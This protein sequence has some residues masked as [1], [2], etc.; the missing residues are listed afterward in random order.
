[1][2]CI[3]NLIA[4]LTDSVAFYIMIIPSI[5]AAA[6]DDILLCVLFEPPCLTGRPTMA[7]CWL[8]GIFFCQIFY[9]LCRKGLVERCV[10]RL[11][12][13][14][15]GLFGNIGLKNL[16]GCPD[17]PICFLYNS[18]AAFFLVLGVAGLLKIVRF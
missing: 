5:L 8:L 2:K 6:A 17:F 3:F 7:D 10:R 16:Y 12:G 13:F 1:M 11:C 4:F 15:F 14:C 18:C 9:R